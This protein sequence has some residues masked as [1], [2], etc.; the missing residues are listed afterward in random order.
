MAVLIILAILSNRLAL[1]LRNVAIAALVLLAVNRL[2]LFTAGFQ[3][4]F[5][6]MAALVILCGRPKEWLAAMAMVSRACHRLGDC[7]PCNLAL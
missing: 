6:A 3:M 1:T 4:S 2:A 7:Q 5:A